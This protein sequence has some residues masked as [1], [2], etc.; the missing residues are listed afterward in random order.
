[1]FIYTHFNILEIFQPEIKIMEAY[2]FSVYD[3]NTIIVVNNLTITMYFMYIYIREI[4]T[5][6]KDG[7]LRLCILYTYT[8]SGVYILN[9]Y[10]H[11]QTSCSLTKNRN[12]VTSYL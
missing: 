11:G 12:K 3:Y 6:T 10:I 9:H 7:L 8:S 1:M 5:C 4:D 2:I